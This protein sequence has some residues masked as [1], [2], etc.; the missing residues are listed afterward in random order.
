M[1]KKELHLL[2][3]LWMIEI[4]ELRCNQE[5]IEGNSKNAYFRV[6]NLGFLRLWD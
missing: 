1:R 2:V 6:G 3:D 4:V 5:L